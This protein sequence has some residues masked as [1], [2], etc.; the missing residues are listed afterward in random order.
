MFMASEPVG[1]QV[2]I[3]KGRGG[4]RSLPWAFTEHGAIMLASVLNSE[5]AVQTRLNLSNA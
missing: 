2:V 1:V 4:R 5:V 3:S